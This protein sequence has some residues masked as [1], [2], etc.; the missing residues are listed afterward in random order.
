MIFAGEGACLEEAFTV[1]RQISGHHAFKMIKSWVN[2][3]ATSHRIQ[4]D[5]VLDCVLGCRGCR[6][7]L[8]LCPLPSHVCVSQI[9]FENISG[10]PLIT[11][12]IQ[13]P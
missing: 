2:R 13:G 9:P 6:D 7:S 10:V 11:F 8:T 1:L 4:E 12:G 5:F 3:W